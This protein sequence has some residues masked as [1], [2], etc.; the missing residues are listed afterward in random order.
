M[1]YIS[2]TTTT[3]RNCLIYISESVLPLPSV[4]FSFSLTLLSSCMYNMNRLLIKNNYFWLINNICKYI[5]LSS[6]VW[7]TPFSLTKVFFLLTHGTIERLHFDSRPVSS[8]IYRFISLSVKEVFN[9]YRC[10]S[11]HSKLYTLNWAEKFLICSSWAISARMIVNLIPLSLCPSV[12][13]SAGRDSA[14]GGH[15]GI[16][17]PTPCQAFATLAL[18]HTEAGWCRMQR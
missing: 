15:V 5:S 8:S 12:R 6:V 13:P 4:L 3:T 10:Y 14:G 17:T 18:E 9:W 7:G 11:D 16:R 1:S 2:E